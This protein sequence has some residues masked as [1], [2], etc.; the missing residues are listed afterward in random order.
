MTIIIPE[1]WLWVFAV[2]MG[3]NAVL[4]VI[5]LVL[6]NRLEKLKKVSHD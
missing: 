1:G 6:A 3:A 2:L 5:Q 4:G